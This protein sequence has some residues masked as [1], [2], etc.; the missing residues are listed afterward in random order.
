M[1]Y[2]RDGGFIFVWDLGVIFLGIPSFKILRFQKF[3]CF[4]FE[5]LGCHKIGVGCFL[6][7]LF[8]GVFFVDWKCKKMCLCGGV[9]NCIA[10][11][12]KFA[13]YCKRGYERI[14]ALGRCKTHY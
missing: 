12:E 1:G 11:Y 4:K 2:C 9:K 8:L 6:V 3:F 5:V 10:T 14:I 7:Y 13:Y